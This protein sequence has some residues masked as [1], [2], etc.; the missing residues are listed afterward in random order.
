MPIYRLQTSPER[1]LELASSAT[2]EECE[3]VC[4]ALLWFI[5]GIKFLDG[6]AMLPECVSEFRNRV[7]AR[8]IEARTERSASAAP[9]NPCSVCVH[10][11]VMSVGNPDRAVCSECQQAVGMPNWKPVEE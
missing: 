4:G 2:P 9:T 11:F 6:S 5:E 10:G 8:F 7:L 3:Q 1:F